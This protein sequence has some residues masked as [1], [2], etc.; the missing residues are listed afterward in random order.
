MKN[1]IAGILALLLLLPSLHAYGAQDFT[2]SLSAREVLR[3]GEIVISGTVPDQQHDVAVK[4]VGPEG[5]MLYLDAVSPTNGRYS[6]RVGIP[7]QAEFAP[8]GK[9]TVYAGYGDKQRTEAFAVM[10]QLPPIGVIP[11]NP[12]QS[13]QSHVKPSLGGN[14]VYVAESNMLASALNAPGESITI[15]L[16]ASAAELGT[17]LEMPA[18]SLRAVD[19]AGK[20]I[21]LTS[22]E[23]KLLFP[24]G[25]I[26]VYG[27]EDSRIRITVN[28]SWTKDA[29]E[30]VEQSI[31]SDSSLRQ[32]GVALSVVIELVT[33]NSKSVIHEMKQPVSVSLKLT[34][35]QE[36]KLRLSLAGIYDVDGEKAVYVPGI[37]KNG[38]FTFHAAHFSYYAVLEYDKRFVDMKEHWA[39][40]AVQAL[41]AKHVVTGVDEQRYMP[42]ANI[43]RADFV[44]ML[45]RALEWKGVDLPD[46]G[47]PVFSDVEKSSYYEEAVGTMVTLGIIKG[48][49]GKF[50]PND[51]MTREEAAAAIARSLSLFELSSSAASK[52]S[53]G[54]QGD[55]ADWAAEAVQAV[56]STG[57]M[58][59]DDRGRF[60]PKSSLTRAQVA[61]IIDR[62][63]SQHS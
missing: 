38:V 59:G 49:D 25:A 30:I 50:R 56:W 5:A 46:A 41:A 45:N 4:V 52:P 48:Y 61:A 7:T 27:G 19:E 21:L 28:T 44:T 11:S 13:N 40:A 58:K 62:A 36:K 63:L 34:E 53:F 17:A 54:D 31:A 32:V 60:N 37:L 6:V 24:A 9:Y 23:H 55:I 29:Q 39:E 1:Y 22:G 18:Q 20:A 3:G 42:E 33:G 15:E 43:K 57:L 12:G 8:Y 26:G 14:G 2:V 16:P 35:E 47:A 51:I 10:L